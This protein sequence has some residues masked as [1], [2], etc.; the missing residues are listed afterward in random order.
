MTSKSKVRSFA[1][2]PAVAVRAAKRAGAKGTG[3]SGARDCLARL[4]L[5][6]ANNTVELLDLLAP[7]G[8]AEAE[9]GPSP[10]EVRGHSFWAPNGLNLWVY[11]AARIGEHLNHLAMT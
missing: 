8:A 3:R 9:G 11:I 4:A 2:A 1:F 10:G 7:V 6:L 5:S